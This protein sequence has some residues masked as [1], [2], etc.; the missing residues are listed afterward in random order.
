M[1]QLWR[2]EKKRGT[3]NNSKNFD[4]SNPKVKVAIYQD[5]KT[6]ERPG[7]EERN[8]GVQIQTCYIWHTYFKVLEAETYLSLNEL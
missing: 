1:D 3:K 7:L 2:C 8:S 4:M 6:E 5:G